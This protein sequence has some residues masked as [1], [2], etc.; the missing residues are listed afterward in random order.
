MENQILIKS[1]LCLKEDLKEVLTE[2]DSKR[3]V[4]AK[5]H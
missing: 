2:V 5:R 4:V 1:P 3:I